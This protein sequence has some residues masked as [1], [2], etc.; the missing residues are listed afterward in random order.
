MVPVIITVMNTTLVMKTVLVSLIEISYFGSDNHRE[1]GHEG[2]HDEVTNESSDG[3]DSGNYNEISNES[4][5]ESL[6]SYDSEGEIRLFS[7]VF[8]LL[9]S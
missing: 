1:S 7:I 4:S 3:P 5:D 6:S 9:L 8:R 2:L